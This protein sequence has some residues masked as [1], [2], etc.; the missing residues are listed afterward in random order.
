MLSSTFLYRR[1]SFKIAKFFEKYDRPFEIRKI[2]YKVFADKLA[3]Y[4]SIINH[5]K[6]LE[7]DEKENNI[8]HDNNIE[9]RIIDMIE[10][11]NHF[12][13]SNKINYRIQYEPKT[14]T[15]I[16]EKRNN[17]KDSLNPD[18]KLYSGSEYGVFN[19]KFDFNTSKTA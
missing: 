8:K 12:V 7:Y 4:D 10:S 18:I 2:H 1:S 19:N 5:L 6:A 16:F 13:K 15:S 17:I 3:L 11:R 14:L 9:Q